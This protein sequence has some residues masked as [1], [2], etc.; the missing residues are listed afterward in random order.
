MILASQSPRRREL[1]EEAGFSLEVLPADID[2]TRLP[3]E[4]PET[5]VGRL[6]REK[7]EATRLLL[8]GSTTDPLLVAADTI[9][10]TDDGEVLGKP[11]DAADARRMLEGLSGRVH[12]V[13]TGVYV[14]L[15]SPA[16]SV[17]KT[18]SFVETTDV[19]FYPLTSGEIRAYA[20]SGE[21]LDKAG[22]YGIQDRG[23]LLVH[24]I[25]GDYF[26]VVGLP[27]ARFVREM[28]RLTGSDATL[29]PLGG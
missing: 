19:E 25:R 24:G 18:T 1:L 16:A 29:G 3:D 15:L 12:H 14:M 20:D 22:A 4:A 2:E 11:A 6:A 28:G 26:N 5:L 13:S 7:A 17:E 27:V 10:W 21:P 8:K 9:V 23:R